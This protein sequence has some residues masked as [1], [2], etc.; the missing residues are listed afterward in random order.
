MEGSGRA[1]YVLFIH[2]SLPFSF[3]EEPGRERSASGGNYYT[4]SDPSYKVPSSTRWPLTRV[5]L[6]DTPPR[7]VC[8]RKTLSYHTTQYY[9]NLNHD[10]YESS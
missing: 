5:I 6:H 2:L 7:L 10:L 9:T 8:G 1:T 4:F 3:R